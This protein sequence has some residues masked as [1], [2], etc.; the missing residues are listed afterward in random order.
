MPAI[1]VI[2]KQTAAMQPDAIEATQ[3]GG[4]RETAFGPQFVI[5]CHILFLTKSKRVPYRDWD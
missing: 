3:L 1:L 4:Y 5:N 2:T